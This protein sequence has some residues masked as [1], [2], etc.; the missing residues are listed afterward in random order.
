MRAD[1]LPQSL[2]ALGTH[3]GRLIGLQRKTRK[4]CSASIRVCTIG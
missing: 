4:L 1:G 3:D 2:P